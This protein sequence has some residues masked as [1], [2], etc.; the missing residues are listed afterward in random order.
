[1]KTSNLLGKFMLGAGVVSLGFL[2]SC[3]K[4][5]E[6][7]QT[8]DASTVTSESVTD[9]YFEDSDDMSVG[10]ATDKAGRIAADDRL[11]CATVTLGANSTKSSGTITIDF[12]T[13]CTDPKGNVRKGKINLSYSGGPAGTIG[14]KVVTTFDGYS[15]NGIKLEGTRTLTL[16]TPSTQGNISHSIVLSGGKATWPDGKIATREC[17]F[18]REVNPTAGTVTLSEGGTASGVTREEKAYTMII[19]SSLVYKKECA[20]QGIYLAAAGT[21]VITSG[22]HAIAINYGTGTCDKSVTVTIDGGFS[23]TITVDK[24]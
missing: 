5:E 13:G 2:G 9:T 22:N 12:G 3:S 1:M 18:D 19:T 4:D 11:T 15:I 20:T 6:G 23:R 21:K 16:Q 24:K 14:F 8:S 7:L 10:V 17:D